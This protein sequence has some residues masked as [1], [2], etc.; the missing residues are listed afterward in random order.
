MMALYPKFGLKPSDAKAFPGNVRMIEDKRQ[1]IDI[2][3]YMNPGQIQIFALNKLDPA[4]MDI[5]VE[6]VI[7]SIFRSSPEEH[8]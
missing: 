6:S 5:F 2:K 4:D 7:A 8:P 3:K 1:A